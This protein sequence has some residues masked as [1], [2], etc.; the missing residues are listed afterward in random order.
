MT[1][2][3]TRMFAFVFLFFALSMPA[4]GQ[5][6]VKVE[7]V[8]GI[9]RHVARAVLADGDSLTAAQMALVERLTAQLAGDT[10][11]LED[12][13]RRAEELHQKRNE[14]MGNI[15]RYVAIGVAALVVLVVLRSAIRAMGKG[16][17][18]GDAPLGVLIATRTEAQA[19]KLGQTLVAENLATGGT[20]AP[21][22]RSIYHRE[23]G[24]RESSEAIIFLKTTHAQLG[25]LINRAD[26]W[27]GGKTSE[28]V[29]IGIRGE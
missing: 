4:V 9:V 11:F 2:R 20:V 24:V 22:M 17:K 1:H 7:R 16:G 14:A 6:R 8:E 29:A 27:G 15:A 18:S 21:S 10:A 28:L 12:Q 26:E 3:K 25:D 23:D 19:R 5:D 13:K